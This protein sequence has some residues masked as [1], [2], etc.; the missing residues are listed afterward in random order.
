MYGSCCLCV[1]WS[2]CPL[3]ELCSQRFVPHARKNHH[4]YKTVLD[5]LHAVLSPVAFHFLPDP[6]GG[7]EAYLASKCGKPRPWIWCRLLH[8]QPIDKTLRVCDLWLQWTCI[9]LRLQTLHS[10]SEVLRHWK[11]WFSALGALQWGSARQPNV[12]GHR[13]RH[14][15]NQVDI[16]ARIDTSIRYWAERNHI[17]H[18]NVKIIW[19]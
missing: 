3:K 4:F 19:K 2:G 10:W 6:D 14:L 1:P 11:Y 13:P 17:F 16:Q 8:S 5:C 7:P 12:L 15:E 9:F 18:K